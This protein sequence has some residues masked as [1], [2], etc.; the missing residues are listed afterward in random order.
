MAAFIDEDMNI[1]HINIFILYAAIEKVEQLA[2]VPKLLLQELKN[3]GHV[4]MVRVYH[5]LKIWF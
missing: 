3:P 2:V 1:L 5:V 4:L